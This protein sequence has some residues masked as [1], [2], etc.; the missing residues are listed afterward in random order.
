MM[1]E[2]EP[3][4]VI[5]TTRYFWSR[6][7]TLSAAIGA[8]VVAH[9]VA[10]RLDDSAASDTFATSMVVVV[11]ALALAVAARSVQVIVNSALSDAHRVF[12]SRHLFACGVLLLA[13]AALTAGAVIVHDPFVELF[14]HGRISGEDIVDVGS[15]CA[16]LVCAVG[17]GV[18]LAG[19]WDTRRDERTWHLTLHLRS[20]RN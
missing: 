3:T 12:R 1:I 13:A 5:S 14:A 2:I 9:P 4:T 8:L 16:A 18:A 11:V 15:A 6:L 17:A 19:A 7:A 20:R 10:H